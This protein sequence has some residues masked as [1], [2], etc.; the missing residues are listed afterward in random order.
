[1]TLRI[2]KNNI[3]KIKATKRRKN[4][5]EKSSGSNA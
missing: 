1:M 3:D 5:F 4:K 2:L